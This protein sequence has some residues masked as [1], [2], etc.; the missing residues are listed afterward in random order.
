M[1]KAFP[2]VAR[3]PNQTMF[4]FVELRHQRDI[5]VFGGGTI[6]G[7]GEVWWVVPVPGLN[8]ERPRLFHMTSVRNIS[9]RGVTLKHSPGGTLGFNS[10][11]QDVLVDGVTVLNPSVG[12]T[13]GIDV[14]CDGALIQNSRVT[15]GDDSICMKSQAKNVLVRNCSV[16]NGRPWPGQ[17]KKGLAG[18]LVLGTSDNDIMRNVTY[19][20]CT[21]TGALAGIRIKFR[22]TQTGNVSGIV[23]EN[24]QIHDPVA[25]A[26]DIDMGT[27][28]MDIRNHTANTHP[29]VTGEGVE[30][31]ALNNVTLRH[32]SGWLSPV[33]RA[34]CGAGRICPRQVARFYCASQLPCAHIRLEHVHVRGFNKTARYPVPCEWTRAS[35]SGVDVS[36]SACLPPER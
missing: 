29:G 32:I 21:V 12:N 19:R 13:D 20:N 18:G 5:A 4:N 25:Y 33:S 10:P 36:P 3:W 23:F 35:G 1:L 2:S 24:I 7:S 11:C 34:L 22:S 16:S 14:G 31:V 8:G 28:H 9:F 26:I 15:N 27:N 30:S 6:D 17:V